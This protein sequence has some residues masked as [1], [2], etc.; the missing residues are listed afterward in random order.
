M[1]QYSNCQQVIRIVLFTFKESIT[2][3]EKEQ[4]ENSEMNKNSYSIEILWI[5]IELS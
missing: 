4:L 2:K 1:E 5:D 3:S